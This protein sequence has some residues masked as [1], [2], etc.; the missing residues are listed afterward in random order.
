MPRLKFG[1]R[2]P[3]RPQ[4][5]QARGMMILRGL[6]RMRRFFPRSKPGDDMRQRSGQFRPDLHGRCQS[7]Q[8]ARWCSKLISPAG[9]GN[10]LFSG[11]ITSRIVRRNRIV[12]R[13]CSFHTSAELA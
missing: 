7:F 10:R 2:Q 8:L 11:S 9:V 6:R 4:S 13:A 1:Q 3:T 5:L 12:C